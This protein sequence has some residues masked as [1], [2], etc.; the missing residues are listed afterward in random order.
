MVFWG[1]PAAA[2]GLS[3]SLSQARKSA[4][5]AQRAHLGS[6]R[7][8]QNTRLLSFGKNCGADETIDIFRQS[9]SSSWTPERL[10]AALLSCPGLRSSRCLHARREFSYT[11]LIGA[12]VN[13]LEREALELAI[14][15]AWETS[16]HTPLDSGPN[17][18]RRLREVGIHEAFPRRGRQV[19]KKRNNIFCGPL[20][21]R[22]T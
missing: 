12:N 10:V 14:K 8:E 5:S 13:T 17:S 22:G 20:F 9:G 1:R 21:L 15:I 16:G 2:G 18:A 11:R 19:L 7:S 4:Q 6:G 3:S